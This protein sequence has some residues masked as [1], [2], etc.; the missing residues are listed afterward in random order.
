MTASGRAA[1]CAAAFFLFLI[2]LVAAAASAVTAAVTSPLN[3]VWHTVV[4]GPVNTSRIWS[5]DDYVHLIAFA[6]HA[7]PSP[8]AANA[9]AFAA[10]QIGKPY[11]WGGTGVPG[12]DCSGLTQAAYRSAGVEIPRVATDQYSEG[13]KVDLKS[14]LPGDLV[15]YGS[16]SFAHHVAIFMGV[17]RGTAVVL[18]APAPHE[19]VRFD[20]LAADDLFAASRPTA[21]R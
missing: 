13:V 4:D 14:L 10:A 8:A 16:P 1:S 5:A 7:A 15:F 18:N 6:E 9:I 12:Y 19:T 2:V 11:V 21:A 3:Q 17:V 20:P